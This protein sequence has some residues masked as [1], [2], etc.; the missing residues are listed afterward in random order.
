MSDIQSSNLT[1]VTQETPYSLYITLR[2]KFTHAQPYSPT[3]SSISDET[4]A[5]DILG[6]KLKSLEASNNNLKGDLAQKCKENAKA[7]EDSKIIQEQLAKVEAD[8]VKH[9]NK[10]KAGKEEQAEEIKLLKESIKKS[11]D[12]IKHL[13]KSLSDR[14][15]S[16]KLK[17][18][19]NYNLHQNLENM[20]EKNKVLKDAKNK[21]KVDQKSWKTW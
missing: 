6:L 19:E 13:N 8:V 10:L 4:A 1:Y 5:L 16:L 7:M 18:K 11:S 17:E 3:Q 20:Q 21:L 9:C 14:N 12:E 15:K 2:K